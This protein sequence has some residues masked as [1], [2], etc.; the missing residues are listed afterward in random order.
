MSI[1][2]SVYTNFRG[3]SLL[4]MSMLVVL[5]LAMQS[6]DYIKIF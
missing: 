3:T 5:P 1:H 4:A 6:S 2:A